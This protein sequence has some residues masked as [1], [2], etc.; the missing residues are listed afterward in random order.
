MSKINQAMIFAAGFGKRLKPLTD[1]TPKPLISIGK[2]TCLDFALEQLKKANI[3]K[4]VVNTHHLSDQIHRH[5]IEL[6][7]NHLSSSDLSS[8]SSGPFRG[9]RDSRNECENDNLGKVGFEKNLLKYPEII[10]SHEP[11]ILETGGGLVHALPYFNPSEPILIVNGDIWWQD[12]QTL[13]LKRLQ[14]TWNSEQMDCLLL[15]VPKEN[16]IGYF[17]KGDYF[18]KDDQHA[19]YRGHNEFAPYVYPGVCIISPLMLT[20]S[21]PKIFSLKSLFDQSESHKRL[22]GLAHD[23]LWGDIGSPQGLEDVRK[24]IKN[25]K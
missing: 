6:Y 17:S 16:S 4:I 7:P 22:Y 2:T 12:S 20:P 24:I 5:L 14:E 11:D 9:S 23:N 1:Q 13:M 15:L 10:I 8:S 3:Q 21:L 19:E 25:F 18:L